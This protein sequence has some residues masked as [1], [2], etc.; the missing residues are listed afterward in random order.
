[1]VGNRQTDKNL[2]QILDY[3][4]PVFKLNFFFSCSTSLHV[5]FTMI[6]ELLLSGGEMSYLFKYK[7]VIYSCEK[8]NHCNS[9]KLTEH[10]DLHFN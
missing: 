7:V 10:L 9:R 1:M 2:E 5:P 8:C 3:D 6:Y 4:V